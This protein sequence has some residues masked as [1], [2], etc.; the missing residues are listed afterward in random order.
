MLQWLFIFIVIAIVAGALGF[1]GISEMAEG[2]AEII[3]FFFIVLFLV[4][5]F[6]MLLHSGPVVV[7]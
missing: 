4:A 3:F 7:L 1:T 2:V 6:L 5:A